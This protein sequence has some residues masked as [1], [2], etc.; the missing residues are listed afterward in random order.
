MHVALLQG[1]LSSER[2]V[3][4]STGRGVE[5]ALN[6]LEH[7]VSVIDVGRDIAQELESIK[8]DIAFNALHGTYGEDGCVQGVLEFLQIPYTHSGVRASAVAM[9][10]PTAKLLFQSVGVRCVEGKVASREEVLAGGVMATPYVIKP[11]AE[12]SSVGVYLV[13]NEEKL[14]SIN[15][16]DHATFLVEKFIAGR[17]VSVAVLEG[18]SLGVVEICPHDGWYDY[19]NKYTAGNTDYLVPAPIEKEVMDEVMAMSES[20]FS[21]MECRGVAR[22]DIRID[23]DGKAFMLEINTHPGMTPTSL[24][25]KIAEYAGISFELLVK[26]LIESARCEYGE[27]A[28]L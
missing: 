28:A 11:L 23:E 8:P 5:E 17:E 9:H 4:L 1:G 24:V 16:P 15:L 25:P 10:K 13:N 3:S 14:A 27:S 2:E 7:R 12:G 19:A 18:K 20:A 21:V 22:T 26:K 6:A